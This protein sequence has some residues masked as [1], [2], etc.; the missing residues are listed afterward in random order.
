MPDFERPRIYRNSNRRLN[1]QGRPVVRFAESGTLPGSESVISA[2][3]REVL[4]EN[5]HV[6]NGLKIENRQIQS[7][8]IR[9]FAFGGHLAGEPDYPL[10]GE[11]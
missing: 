6:I 8:E 5:C 2:I 7:R 10:D 9:R 3:L 4:S 11:A 1:A